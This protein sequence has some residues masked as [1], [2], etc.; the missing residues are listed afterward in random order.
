MLS[1]QTIYGL[2]SRSN[3]T[4]GPGEY[5]TPAT[6]YKFEDDGSQFSAIAPVQKNGTE[7]RADGLAYSSTQGLWCFELTSTSTSTLHQID[8]ATASVTSAGV[9]FADRQIFGAA[10][11]RHGQLWAIDQTSDELLTIDV[12]AGQMLRHIPLTLEGQPFNLQSASGDICFN[13]QGK[14]FLVD[15]DVIYDLNAHTGVLTELFRNQTSNPKFLVGAVIPNNRPDTLIVFDVTMTSVDNDDI[16]VYNLISPSAPSYLF[17]SILN[18]YNAGRGDLATDVPAD[19]SVSS[20]FD[21]DAEGW[22]GAALSLSNLSQ[23]VQTLPISHNA[24]GS[25]GITDNDNQWTTFAA[26]TKYRGDKSDWLGG[27][28]SLEMQSLTSGTRIDG[29]VVFLV[30]DGIALCSPWIL[31]SSSWQPYSVQLTPEGWHTQT[32][33]G[34]E[35]SVELMYQVLSNL[36]AMYIVGDYVSGNETTSI[37]NVQMIS[38]LSA[39]SNASGFVDL[40]DFAHFAAQWSQ[41]NCGTA[42]WCNGQD[43]NKNGVISLN[44]LDYL[45]INWLLEMH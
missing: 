20:T 11:D 6:L 18:N 4:G 35:P 40:E 36:Q 23:I 24:G 39:D 13:A 38:G 22:T 43:F 34:P 31:P 44:D 28:I 27:H 33:D 2:K 5:L 8:P 10:F 45:L 26:P 37:D 42:E 30:S 16:F 25:I 7:I 17:N 21:A 14:V 9:V 15:N 19:L 1:A 29:P 32:P 12:V 3:N 41:T